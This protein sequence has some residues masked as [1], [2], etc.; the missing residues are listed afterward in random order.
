MDTGE[1]PNAGS[2]EELSSLMIETYRHCKNYI[3]DKEV[4]DVGCGEG[5][6]DLFMADVAK[7]IHGI[8]YDEGVILENKNKFSQ[9]KNITFYH[10]SGDQ[11]TFDDSSFDVVISSQSIEHIDDDKRFVREVHRVLKPGGIFICTTPNK[12]SLIPEGEEEYD[13]PYYPY[14]FREY[15]PEQFFGL[16]GE[17]FGSV[18]EM[19]FYCPGGH[20]A[21]TQHIRARIIYRLSRFKVVRWLGRHMSLKV[22]RAIYFF[23]SDELKEAVKVDYGT[24]Y[25]PYSGE[26]I[27]HNLCAICRKN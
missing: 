11:M 9:A 17:Q 2:F 16:L 24:V 4:L 21:H 8:D 7:H 27:P 6:Q 20:P 23:G 10:M 5:A 18:E 22:K 25:G 15:R 1:R 12:L 3:V 13:A 19:C 14:H 26:L